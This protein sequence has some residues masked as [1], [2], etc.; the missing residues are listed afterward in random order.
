[1][2]FKSLLLGHSCDMINQTPD[3]YNVAV[4]HRHKDFQ[5]PHA[6]HALL[7]CVAKDDGFLCLLG[8]G[9]FPPTASSFPVCN[10]ET[11]ISLTPKKT[12]QKKR[13]GLKLSQKL[14]QDATGL[15]WSPR[16]VSWMTHCFW[17]SSGWTA[18][19]ALAKQAWLLTFCHQLY[20]RLGKSFGWH[21][22]TP[23]SRWTTSTFNQRFPFSGHRKKKGKKQ[24]LEKYWRTK[25]SAKFNVDWPN[26]L[27]PFG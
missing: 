20:Q 3:Q 10:D 14:S 19:K 8:G 24:I 13:N 22:K 2:I 15:P 21:R 9:I 1:M 23:V 7:T 4:L 26:H 17:L 6:R 18:H 25:V 16:R 11:V 5:L 27:D 12:V